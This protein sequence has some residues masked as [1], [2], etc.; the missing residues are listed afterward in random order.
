MA[1][2]GQ[3]AAHQGPPVSRPLAL[4]GEGEGGGEG[5]GEEK[6]RERQR[7]GGVDRGPGESPLSRALSQLPDADLITLLQMLDDS[8]NTPQ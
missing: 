8:L 1:P 4:Q 3:A 7:E 6:G 2:E 5:Y